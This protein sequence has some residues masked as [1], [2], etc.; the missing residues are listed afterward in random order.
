[1]TELL[2]GGGV[3]IITSIITY[4]IGA[5]KSS[6]E[7]RKLN[8]EAKQIEVST[9]IDE[10]KLLEEI[11]RVL[12]EQNEKNKAYIA[13]LELR[14]DELEELLE[15]LNSKQCLG[16]ACPTKQAYDKIIAKRLARKKKT[17][18]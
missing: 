14:I 10:V 3:A 7:V 12:D 11:N 17:A 8:A 9:R 1:M 13:R 5:N 4:V 6:A 2:V 15:N 18:Q 16:D